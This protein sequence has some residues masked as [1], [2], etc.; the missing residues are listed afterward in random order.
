MIPVL[1]L[2]HGDTEAIGDRDERIAVTH[3]VVLRMIS[4]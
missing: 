4:G 2:L 1:E 3:G